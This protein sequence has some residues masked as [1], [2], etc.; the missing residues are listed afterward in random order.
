MATSIVVTFN[1]VAGNRVILNTGQLAG[2][3]TP[4][5][6]LLGNGDSP[7]AR[8]TWNAGKRDAT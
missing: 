7:D 1:E 4:T 5:R 6:T 8:S 3:Q 2:I